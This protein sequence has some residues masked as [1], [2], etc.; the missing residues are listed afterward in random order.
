M[1][2]EEPSILNTFKMMPATHKG[3]QTRARI[4]ESALDLFRRKGYEETTMRA[5]ARE[6]RVSLGNTYYYFRSKEQLIQAFYAR[7][8]AEHLASCQE[9]L[10][11]ETDLKSRLLE[12][13]KAK[14]GTSMPYHRFSGILFRTAADPQ[15]PLH[16]F[17]EESRPVREQS[18]QIFVRVVEGSSTRIPEVLRR[19]LPE[20]LWLH[21]MGIILFWIHDRSPGCDRT[22]RLIERSVEIVARLVTIAGL[23]PVRP[24]TRSALRLLRELRPEVDNSPGAT[25]HE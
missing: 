14:I 2:P 25:P 10:E 19:E 13:F 18:L 21:L 20:L 15:S 8:H 3:E 17:S 24:L 1:A 5:I 12:V 23:P 9:I 22:Y 16:P 6:A 11:Q 4:L 7:S